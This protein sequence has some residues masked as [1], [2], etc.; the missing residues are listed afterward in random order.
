MTTLLKDY[1]MRLGLIAC[2]LLALPSVGCA[3]GGLFYNWFH[4]GTVQQQRFRATLH[5]PY[6]DKDLGPEVVGGRPRDFARPLPE[7][8]KSRYLQ[9]SYWGRR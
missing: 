9:D 7:P 3:G 8:V 4:P 5:D 2:L 6:S 1:F